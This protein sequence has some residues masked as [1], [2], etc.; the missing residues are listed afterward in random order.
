M[1]IIKWWNEKFNKPAE[2]EVKPQE[3]DNCPD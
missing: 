3:N 2:M 1:G